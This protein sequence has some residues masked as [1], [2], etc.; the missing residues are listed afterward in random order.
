VLV[1]ASL[2]ELLEDVLQLLV[3]LRF[4]LPDILEFDLMHGRTEIVL[5]LRTLGLLIIQ[6]LPC[7]GEVGV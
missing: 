6:L 1:Y 3:C 7:L 2:E 5:Y 4:E